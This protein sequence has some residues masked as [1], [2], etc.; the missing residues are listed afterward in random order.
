MMTDALATARRPDTLC[1]CACYV[2]R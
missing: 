1:A 2:V